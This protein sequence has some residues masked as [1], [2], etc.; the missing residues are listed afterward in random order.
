MQDTRRIRNVANQNW[1]GYI[2]DVSEHTLRFYRQIGV[3]AVSMPMRWREAPGTGDRKLVP[4]TQTR[5]K[6]AQGSV[7]DERALQR[8]MARIEAFDLQPLVADLDISGRVFDGQARQSGRF[9]DRQSQY[10]NCRAAGAS[11]IALQFYGPPSIRRV[12][13]AARCRAR[14]RGLAGF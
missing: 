6:G 2:G 8:I 1:Q 9:G 5:P 4:P 12:C 3:E 7:W 13:C 10:R 11:G 14:R